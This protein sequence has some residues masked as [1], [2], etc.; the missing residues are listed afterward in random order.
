ME[1]T[2]GRDGDEHGFGTRFALTG[3]SLSY[4]KAAAPS[5]C[6]SPG[7]EAA[8]EAGSRRPSPTAFSGS[9]LIWVA[10]LGGGLG[11]GPLLLF[12]VFG[13]WGKTKGWH[14]RT[15]TLEALEL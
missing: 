7:A 5:S 9:C 11:A 3:P 12:F 2:I 6:P 10:Q 13:R 15:L 1:I 8:G 4:R 14:G